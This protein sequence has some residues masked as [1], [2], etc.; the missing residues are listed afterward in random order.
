VPNLLSHPHAAQILLDSD[1]D[2][3]VDQDEI[4]DA[5]KTM[6][7]QLSSNSSSSRGGSGPRAVVLDP[8]VVPELDKISH[9]LYSNAVSC[10]ITTSS[11]ELEL[12][13]CSFHTV[14]PVWNLILHFM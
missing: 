13:H 14:K 6:M 3:R 4:L 10:L 11:C 8:S 1:G 9:L 7:A 12:A 2:R 5:A